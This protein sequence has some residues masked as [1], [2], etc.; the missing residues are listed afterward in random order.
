MLLVKCSLY[1]A[2]RYEYKNFTRLSDIANASPDGYILRLPIYV[3]GKRDSLIKFSARKN[4]APNADVY[5]IGMLLQSAIQTST[6][7]GE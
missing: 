4:P 2:D 5:E 7:E 1:T 6:N 3:Q